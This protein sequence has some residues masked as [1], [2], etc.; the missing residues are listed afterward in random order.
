MRSCA[1]SIVEGDEYMNY[2]AFRR[3]YRLAS[4]PMG[5]RQRRGRAKIVRGRSLRRATR[6]FEG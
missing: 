5:R 3:V 6:P 4:L 2:K 1:S